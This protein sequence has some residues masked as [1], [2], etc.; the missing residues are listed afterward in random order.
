[1]AVAVGQSGSLITS[2]DGIEWTPHNIRNGENLNSIAWTGDRFVA[3]GSDG[4][5]YTSWDYV[6]WTK[7]DSGLPLP[8]PDFP[9]TSPN[10]H[11]RSVVC[12]SGLCVAVADSGRIITSPQG[13]AWTLQE[14]K[15][16]RRLMSVILADDR[17]VAVGEKGTVLTSAEGSVWTLQPRVPGGFFMV[18][19]IWTGSRLVAITA[20]GVI[21]NSTDG[22]AWSSPLSTQFEDLWDVAWTG[23]LLVA[24][25][26]R[27]KVLHSTDS[28]IWASYDL[29]SN[30]NMTGII[31]AQGK[32][33]AI[34]GSTLLTSTDGIAWSRWSGAEWNPGN[35]EIGC[36]CFQDVT[37]TGSLFVAVGYKGVIVTSPDGIA[38]TQARLAENTLYTTASFTRVSW[39]GERIVA[40]NFDLAHVSADGVEWERGWLKDLMPEGELVYQ[41]EWTGKEW[42]RLSGATVE[43]ASDRK[44]FA[45]RP[46]YDYRNTA[47]PKN[48]A[49]TGSELVAVG[50]RG[51]INSWSPTSGNRLSLIRPRARRISFRIDRSEL[52]AAL[53]ESLRGKP[54]RISVYTTEGR[55]VAETGVP[56]AGGDLRMPFAAGKRGRYVAVAESGAETWRTLIVPAF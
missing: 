42:I 28:R 16:T 56:N 27:G 26:N 51:V 32:L 24:V 40:K 46:G 34:A 20:E 3:V 52:V 11:L 23:N 17:F 25:G 45:F 9:L 29:D 22:S 8:N 6:E 1:M 49:W 53:S 37:W 41:A 18:S 33:V 55:K 14:R 19:V 47:P 4:A 43:T 7:R 12:A 15:T 10:N 30:T 21:L 50:S 48:W 44:D 5:I 39:T 38:W 36:N 13:Q 35:F 54:I 2:P 31:W